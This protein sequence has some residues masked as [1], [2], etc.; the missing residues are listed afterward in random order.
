MNPQV[1]DYDGRCLSRLLPSVAGALGVPGEADELDL[2]EFPRVCTVLVDGLGARLLAER[3]GH[4]PF[5]R[6]AAAQQPDGAPATLLSVVP[7][8]TA[9]ALTSLG[10]ALPPARHGVIGYRCFDPDGDRVVNHLSWPDGL[11]PYLWQPE[12]TV[13]DRT[14]AAGVPVTMV[15]P[16]AFERSGLTQAALRGPRF[17]AAESL[18]DRVQ[19][20][21][22]LLDASPRA[23]V[24]VYWG[25]VDKVGHSRGC[26]SHEW[27]GEL[28][29]IDAALAQLRRLAPRDALVVVTADHGMVDCP[30]GSRLDVAASPGLREGV[31]RT[32]GEPRLVQLRTAPGQAGAVAARWADELGER[33]WVV[34]AEQ[35]VAAGWF[36]TRPPEPHVRARVGDVL[37]AA[38]GDLAVVDTDHDDLKVLAMV[39]QHGSLTEA[40]MLVPLLRLV[41]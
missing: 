18:E 19:A 27:A 32:A 21:A 23:M 12:P 35:A 30:P 38:R 7:S 24:N 34:T 31:L 41:P 26:G 8:T 25:D 6:R 3:G 4:A 16:A 29:R 1:P 2:G 40:E 14:A 20:A 17:V 9:T 22:R 36:G 11:D 13:F 15:A 28:E 5:L 33:A 10:T 39:G 37:V